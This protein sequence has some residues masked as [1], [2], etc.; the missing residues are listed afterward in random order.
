MSRSRHLLWTATLALTTGALAVGT[1]VG[2]RVTNTATL[3]YRTSL[4]A[5]VQIASLP[6]EVVVRQVY[7]LSVTPD[8][9]AGNVPAARRFGAFAG[10]DRL[11]PYTLTNNGNGSDT[12][13][14]SVVQPTA[15]DDFDFSNVAI[16]ADADNNGVADGPALTSLTLAADAST[17][18][19]VSVRT[20]AGAPASS[21][22]LL[23][24]RAVSAGNAAAIDENNYAR[25]DVTNN[26]QLSLS[27]NASPAGAVAPGSA[28]TYAATGGNASA[29]SA[30]NVTGAVTVDGTPRDGIFVR[31]VLP[32]GMRLASIDPTSGSTA[33]AATVLYSTDGG[34]TWTATAPAVLS[35]VN[36]VGLLISGAG[37]F[38]PQNATYA[39][40]FTAT[41]PAGAAAGTDLTNRATVNFDGNADGDGADAGETVTSLATNNTVASVSSAA[42]GPF[43]FPNGDGSGAYTFGGQTIT[44]AGDLQTMATPVTAGTSVTFK[45]TLLNTG[46]ALNTFN[47]AVD[48]SPAGWTCR[49]VNVDAAGNL[50]PLNGAVSLP[51][52]GRVDLAAQCDIPLPSTNLTN[53]EIRVVAT[54]N[55]GVPDYSLDRVSQVN[56]AGPVLLGNGDGNPATAPSTAP[57]TVT[58]APGTPALFVL[59]LQNGAPVPEAY[60]LSSTVP[61]GYGTPVFYLDTNCDGTPDGGPITQTPAV[62]PGATVCLIAQVT[63]PPG[64]TAGSEPVQFTATSTTT[65]SRTSTVTDTI[66]VSGVAAATFVPDRAGNAV[67][68]A[69]VVYTHTLTNTSN[70]AV[71][72]AVPAFTSPKGWTYEFSTDGV[73]YAPQLTGLAL[74]Q[75]AATPIYVRVS[76]PA[77]YAAG[78]NDT[79]AAPI[80]AVVTAAGAA[81]T[82]ST[83]TVVDTTTALRTSATVTKEAGL[84]NDASCTTVTPLA[85]GA[86]V[87]PGDIVRYTIVATNTGDAA[88]NSVYVADS[89]PANTEFVAVSA[90]GA[91]VGLLYSV[92][93]GQT[94]TTTA[95]SS[96]PGG[97][98]R[99]GV[100]SDGDSSVGAGDLF[101]AGQSFTVRFDVRIR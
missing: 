46:N 1:P 92:D 36:A 2:T 30:G 13:N 31:D 95:P 74:A 72:V 76:I 6:V 16:Y 54:P 67:P 34:V 86:A 21:S 52:G 29:T 43:E 59:E 84:C 20:P 51:A 28:I 91:G 83:V 90:T 68:G 7:A 41:V 93:G 33:G 14:L 18:V 56:A 97:S 82:T 88:Q 8:A 58:A 62:A 101:G 39:L 80:R 71:T 77:A 26:A 89:L 98:I 25:V 23:D 73:T 32:G 12:F 100:N 99:I 47:V 75:G 53:A 9:D 85:N 69:N 24:L 4:G 48:Q 79:E 35:D 87:S 96:L 38:F 63:P 65:P 49:V 50:S 78:A 15:G 94:W 57:V 70:G 22:G 55:G 10:Q 64:R 81:G 61:G 3:D 66:G 42:F 11:I 17:G 45:Q 19:L 37:A 27:L 44:R 60:N 40:R 5:P